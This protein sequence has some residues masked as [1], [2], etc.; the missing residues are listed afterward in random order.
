MSSGFEAYKMYL[1]LKKHFTSEYNFH[2]YNGKVRT[3]VNAFEKRKDKYIF[4]KIEKK[5]SRN[6]K[7]F[8]L[9]NFLEDSNAWIGNMNEQT[10]RQWKIENEGMTYQ[11]QNDLNF[12]QDCMNDDDLTVDDII[13]VKYGQH[14]LLLKWYLGKRISLNTLVILQV[15]GLYLEHWH[16]KLNDPVAEEVIRKI[17]KSVG[18]FSIDKKKYRELVKKRL[19]TIRSIT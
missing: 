10:Y 8:F 2:T 9:S 6:L 3:S 19:L 17:E 18:F 14:P 16:L 13:R 15:L 11:F 4:Q 7:E 1:A 5:F 12:I